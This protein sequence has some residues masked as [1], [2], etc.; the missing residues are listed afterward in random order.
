LGLHGRAHHLPARQ[1]AAEGRWDGDEYDL[2]VAGVVEQTALFGESVRLTREIRGRLGENTIALRD[3]V[4]NVGFAPTPLMILYHFNFGFPLM[5]EETTV[6][7]PSRRVVGREKSLPLEGIT[8]WQAPAEDYAE[9][10][11]YHEDLKTDAAGWTTVTIRNPRFPLAGGQ[12]RRPVAVS[13]RWSTANLPRLAQ[14]KMPGIG[15]YVLGIEPANCHV[16]GRAAERKRGTLHSLE[17]GEALTYDVEL[18]VT[19]E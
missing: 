9:R 11:Y 14:W 18:D 16:E 2:R 8:T 15:V 12:V 5:D 3:L 19:M 4:E 13:L 6:E 7:F 17:P 1:V 10:V